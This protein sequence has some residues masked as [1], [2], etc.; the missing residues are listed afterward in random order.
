MRV[1]SKDRD[2]LGIDRDGFKRHARELTDLICDKEKRNAAKDGE[3]GTSW[4]AGKDEKELTLG[5]EKTAKIKKFAKGYVDKL[6]ARREAKMQQR[7]GGGGVAAA[8]SVGAAAS[9]SSASSASASTATG[10]PNSSSTAATSVTAG[11]S[12]SKS[13]A[14]GPPPPPPPPGPPPPRLGTTEDA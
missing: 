7:E 10:T 11:A 13:A 12:S 9:S 3:D 1:L 2:R 5:T 4:L 6:V 14:P 8:P